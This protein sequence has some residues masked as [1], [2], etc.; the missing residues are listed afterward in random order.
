MCAPQSP[1][2]AKSP[3]AELN[4]VALT[5]A[6]HGSDGAPCEMGPPDGGASSPGTDM[7]PASVM[8][9]DVSDPWVSSCCSMR[10]SRLAT[11]VAPGRLRGSCGG[12]GVEG[13]AQRRHG[14]V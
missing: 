2:L 14:R 8:A 6:V 5:E 7:G 10:L 13:N 1:P 9:V 12:E 11:S 3:V 4:S